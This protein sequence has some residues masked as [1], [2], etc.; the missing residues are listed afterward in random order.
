MYHLSFVVTTHLKTESL[1]LAA[2]YL[3]HNSVDHLALLV[4]VLFMCLVSWQIHWAGW[5]MMALAGA[6]ASAH[7]ACYP[8][9]S[10][11]NFITWW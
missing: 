2:I 1:K 5:Y 3:A 10:F 6:G 11:L 7:V 4:S 8:S 9:A